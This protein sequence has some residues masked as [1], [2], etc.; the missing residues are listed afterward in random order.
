MEVPALLPFDYGID[1]GSLTI[2]ILRDLLPC[3]TTSARVGDFSPS[4][5]HRSIEYPISLQYYL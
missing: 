5:G 2:T 1:G 3:T 4:E